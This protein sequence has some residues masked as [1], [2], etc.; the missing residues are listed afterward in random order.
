METNS[1]SNSTLKMPSGKGIFFL[2]LCS[3][4]AKIMLHNHAGFK[5]FC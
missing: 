5:K 4:E 1:I 2:I 3:S